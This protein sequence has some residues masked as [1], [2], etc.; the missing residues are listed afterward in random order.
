MWARPTIMGAPSISLFKGPLCE[1]KTFG[2]VTI[3][4]DALLKAFINGFRN[5]VGLDGCHLKGNEDKTFESV[6][7]S[8]DAPM[9]AFINGFR[10][11]VGLDG[12]HLK[13]K[14]GGCL[15]SPTALDGQNG[16]VPLGIMICKNE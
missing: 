5:V 12:C 2:S 4:F 1:D 14:Y 3:S 8:F 10:N 11:V 6:T 9:K 15:L 16:L 7:I 13:G